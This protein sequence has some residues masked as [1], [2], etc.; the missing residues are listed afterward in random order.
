M[1]RSKIEGFS[2]AACR[3]D[4]QKRDTFL[5]RPQEE[6]DRTIESWQNTHP[7]S[8]SSSRR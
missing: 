2:L 6:V 1:K 5:A 8:A 7:A 3:K 4:R